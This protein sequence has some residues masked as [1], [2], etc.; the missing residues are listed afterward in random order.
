[1]TNTVYIF[2]AEQLNKSRCEYSIR[3]DRKFDTEA[4]AME[5]FENYDIAN[6]FRIY[7]ETEG[8]ESRQGT[9]LIASVIRATIEEDGFEKC[10]PMD[11]IASKEYSWSDYVEA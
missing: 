11:E 7:A 2:T 9:V 4:E 5:F 10:D 1:M 3:C 8:R 6:E